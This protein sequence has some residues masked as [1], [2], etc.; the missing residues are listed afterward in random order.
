[1]IENQEIY[2]KK[3][4]APVIKYNPMSAIRPYNQYEQE[5]SYYGDYHQVIEDDYPPVLYDPIKKKC[6]VEKQ[7]YEK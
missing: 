4:K 6:A 5:V 2:E 7:F 1:M 3:T